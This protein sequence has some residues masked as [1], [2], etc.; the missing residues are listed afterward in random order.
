MLF[1]VIAVDI[2]VSVIYLFIFFHLGV[3]RVSP[4]PG[5]DAPNSQQPFL[6]SANLPL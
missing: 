5:C 2:V 3:R 1:A 6:S 4:A